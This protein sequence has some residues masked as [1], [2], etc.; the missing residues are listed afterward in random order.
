MWTTKSEVDGQAK[1]SLDAAF[2]THSISKKILP[3]TSIHF[4]NKCVSFVIF[5]ASRNRLDTILHTASLFL[6][7]FAKHS[8]GGRCLI[9]FNT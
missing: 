8:E 9:A 4:E 6:I 2:P 5:S 1:K 7:N 3:G